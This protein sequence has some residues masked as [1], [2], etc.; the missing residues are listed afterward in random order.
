MKT[1]QEVA[2]IIIKSPEEANNVQDVEGDD[3]EQEAAQ[4]K[5]EDIET[6]RMYAWSDLSKVKR[7]LWDKLHAVGNMMGQS[8]TNLA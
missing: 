2:D 7:D 3:N 6:N 5:I 4:K 8:M 1:P